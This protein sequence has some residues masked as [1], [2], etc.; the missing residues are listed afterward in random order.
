MT[1]SRGKGRAPARLGAMGRQRI[2]VLGDGLGALSTVFDLTD[3]PDWVERYEISLYQQGWRLGG[4]CASGRDLRDGY[5]HRILEHGRSLFGGFYNYSFAMLRR[6]YETL[7]RPE[8]H[9]NRTVWDAFT[10]LDAI[11]LVDRDKNEN[12]DTL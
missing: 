12:G 11:A 7:A 3:Q 9:P 4:K 8:G 6:C 1:A 5:G 2:A 10:G